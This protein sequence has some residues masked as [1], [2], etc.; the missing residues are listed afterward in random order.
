MYE[1]YNFLFLYLSQHLESGIIDFLIK[2]TDV[3]V[4]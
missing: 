3:R 1:L 4:V 2:Y